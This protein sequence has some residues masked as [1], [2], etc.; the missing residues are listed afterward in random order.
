[1]N[2]ILHEIG[3]I[4]IMPVIVLEHAEYAGPLAKALIDGGLPCAE[5][6][7]RTA[8]AK[9][10]IA[11]I[12]KKYPEMLLGAG[13]VLT[14]DQVKA[15]KDA[16]AKFIVSPGLNPKVVE[17]CL[18]ENIPIIP[19]VATPS[20]VERAMDHGLEVVKFFP[21]ESN[22]GVDYLKALAG[23]FRALHFIPTG[24]I[25]ENNF[26]SYLSY[27]RV[28]ACGGSWMVR[29]DFVANHRFDEITALTA[30]AVQKMLG[31]SLRHVGINTSSEQEAKNTASQ[32]TDMFGFL[33]NDKGG[34]I[35]VG[36]AFEVIKNKYLGAHGH[37]A[38]A[39]NSVE[40]ALAFLQR[41]NIGIKQETKNFV[42]GKLQTVYLDV[43]VA[44]FAVHL[45]QL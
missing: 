17:Y 40:R 12:A 36:T 44:G 14:V 20:E 11:C 33:P 34:A 45:V 26:M 16:G 35:F 18:K 37:I 15:A 43:D 13:T 39:T 2:Q 27:S 32:L 1:M 38:I 42:N 7:F 24:G 25:N 3:L 41:H 21:A 9:D 30:H 10:S 6:T 8:A 4:G 19:G 22:G 23:P 28:L 29:P 5:V 31:F